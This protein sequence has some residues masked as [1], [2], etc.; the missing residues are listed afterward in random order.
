MANT[1]VKFS[2]DYNFVR[3]AGRMTIERVLDRLTE[4]A[5]RNLINTE[6]IM[7]SPGPEKK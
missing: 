6:C 2:D 5:N 1:H 3:T 4:W 7:Q